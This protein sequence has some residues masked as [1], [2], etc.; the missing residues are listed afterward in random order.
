MI[1]TATITINNIE[2]KVQFVDSDHLVLEAH[3]ALGLTFVDKKIILIDQSIQPDYLKQII[4]HELTHAFLFEYMAISN[5]DEVN[6]ET[7]CYFNQ[8]YLEQILYYTNYLL[9]FQEEIIK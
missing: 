9:K 6:I 3:K 7:L 8:R 1:D 2:Y 5:D 4:I